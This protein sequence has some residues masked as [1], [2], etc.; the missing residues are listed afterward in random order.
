[1]KKF[2]LSFM[3]VL[4]IPGLSYASSSETGKI[5]KIVNSSG[6]VN[7]VSVWLNGVDDQS[8]CPAGDRWTIEQGLDPGFK[9][10]LATILLAYALKETVSFYHSSPSGCG[11]WDSRKIY[12][13]EILESNQ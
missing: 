1:M 10:K 9:G 6:G 3:F 12:Y 4:I 5:T 13:I 8:E 2:L 11:S 7:R